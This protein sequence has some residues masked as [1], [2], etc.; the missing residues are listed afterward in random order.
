MVLKFLV[1][2]Q[3]LYLLSRDP[4]IADSSGY[5]QANFIFS[6]DWEGTNKTA[7]FKRTE[8]TLITD[9]TPLFFNEEIDSNGNCL[10]PWEVLKGKGTFN[11]NVFGQKTES[12]GSTVKTITVNS[13]DIRVGE[14][15][16][17][18][19]EIPQD[20][21]AS[22]Y[23]NIYEKILAAEKETQTSQAAAAAS[24]AAAKTSE[25][26]AASSATSAATSAEAAAASAA[27]VKTSE[28][29]AKASET[30]AKTSETNAANS[31]T[32]ASNETDTAKAW[33]TSTESPDGAADTDSSTG[34][35]QSSKT[36]ALY[37]KDWAT[38]AASSAS[39]AST[40]ATDASSSAT[41]AASSASAASTSATNAKNSQTAA[42]SSAS[43]AATSETNAATHETNAKTALASCQNIQSQV[44]S[45]L[46]A[47]TSAVKYRG[48]VASYSDLPTSGLSTGDMYNVKA[49]GGT[50]SNGTAIKAGD[51]LVYNGSGWD[52]QSGTVDLSNYYTKTEMAGA[53]MSTSVS[54]DTITFVHKD[55]STSTATVNNV[56]HATKAS[57]DDNGQAIDVA[58]LKEL[59]TTTVNAGITTALEKV[60]PVGSIYTSLTDSRNPNTILGF[61]TWTAI[62]AG[63]TLISAGTVTDEDGT[64]RTYTAGE[65]YGANYS[66]IS[67]DEI[68]KVNG[69]FEVR[70]F[71]LNSNLVDV[72][73][74]GIVTVALDA[75]DS[76]SGS[77]AATS[78]SA[79]VK[80]SVVTISLGGDKYH[81][82][83]QKGT[84]AY[85][86]RRQP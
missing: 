63:T 84:C 50:D 14:S 75:G 69:S 58:A 74:K 43:A 52:D 16:L 26:N 4:V 79:T 34:K 33:A 32:L 56:G 30:A 3:T 51:N 48:S 61:G 39:T 37:S 57:Q 10:V 70:S 77:A 55:A 2:Y 23:D 15:G 28:T 78:Q 11:V 25:T 19:D 71:N 1:K 72:Y 53:V 9:G 13:L 59:I 86:W 62:E 66:Q 21:T 29:N 18:T 8:S 68:E 44:N 22:Q 54:N 42:A 6:D 35:T 31:A 27:S 83:I 24:Q 81:S 36:W 40:K 12:D 47:L 49:A 38:A 67:V 7:Q 73:K 5:L 64:S 60:F 80:P 41:A 45:G 20:S 65:T 17:T 82:N 85:V 46:Q 76:W